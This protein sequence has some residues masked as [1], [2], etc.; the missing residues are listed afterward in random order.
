L[1]ILG[2]YWGIKGIGRGGLWWYWD[3]GMGLEVLMRYCGWI[4]S[5]NWEGIEV[6][7]GGYWGGIEV[8]GMVLQAYCGYCVGIG[9]VLDKNILS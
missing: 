1:R 7:R 9:T 3:I 6:L 5:R 4:L 8:L 2:G